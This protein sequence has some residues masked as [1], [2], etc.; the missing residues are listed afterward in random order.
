MQLF[1]FVGWFPHDQA[2]LHILGRKTME[3]I[4]FSGIASEGILLMYP[5]IDVNIDHLVVLVFTKSLDQ[6]FF[7]IRI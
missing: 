2:W 3:T 6:F 7:W 5:N 1:H 4:P